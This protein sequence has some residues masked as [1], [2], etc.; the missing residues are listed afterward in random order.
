M[1]VFHFT[2]LE[3]SKFDQ[4]LLMQIEKFHQMINN[5]VKK[6]E[7]Q[8]QVVSILLEKVLNLKQFILKLISQRKSTIKPRKPI[9][10]QKVYLEDNN[11][12]MNLEPEL[13]K[14]LELEN[15]NLV[16]QL[17]GDLE[18]IRIATQTISQVSEMQS[19][20]AM[21]L[22]MQTESIN[23]IER[24]VEESKVRVEQGTKHLRQAK[25]IF[26]GPKYWVLYFFCFLSVL[27]LAF[28]FMYS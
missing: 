18:Q 23:V 24:N 27:L 12:E 7:F 19:S 14:E 2:E 11:T 20:I 28:D 16:D 15:R 9:S 4:E 25:E 17:D 21:H 5:L 6:S 13:L 1:Q 8:Q 22:S 3:R 26:G 10:I